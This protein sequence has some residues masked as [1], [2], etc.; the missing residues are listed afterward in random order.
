MTTT[1]WQSTLVAAIFAIHPLH[2]ESVAWIAERRDVLYAFFMLLT[3]WAYINYLEKPKRCRHLWVLL[4]FILAAMS[5]PMVV[6]MPFILLLLDYWPLGR[7]RMANQDRGSKPFTAPSLQAIRQNVPIFH[8]FVEKFSLFSIAAVISL[9][10][11]FS[12]WGANALSSLEALP[13]IVRLEN[14]VVSYRAYILKM[15]WPNPL[16]VLYPH[17]IALPV[18]KIVSAALLLLTI[19]ILVI[20]GRKKHP[21][22]I[23]GWLWYLITLLPVIGLVQA[24]IQSMADRFMYMPMTGLSIMVIYGISDIY[25]TWPYKKLTLTVLT[26]LLL[27][28]LIASTRAQVKLWQNSETLFRHTLQVTSNN[29]LI[30]NNLGATLA[31]QGKDEE[32]FIHFMR[33]LEINP[34]YA[35]AHYNLGSLLLRQGKDREAI[36]HLLVALQIK[37]DHV[38]AHNDLGI[39]LTRYGKSKEA[40]DHFSKAIQFDPTY[41]EAY[42]NEGYI[43]LQQKNYVEAIFYFKEVLRIN[44]NNS[45]AYNGLGVSFLESGSAEKAMD[46]Y[47]KALEINPNDADTH[48]NLGSLFIR[49]GKYQEAILHFT[50][51]LRI[52]P[53]DGEVHFTLGMLYLKIDQKEL[54]LKQYTILKTINN[55]MA[56]TLYR[57]ISRHRN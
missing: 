16:A 56:G 25:K 30:H 9:F 49:Q 8:L 53:N 42:F 51:A 46:C 1:L 47:H 28:T 15:I 24:G 32:A 41:E 43:L 52:N 31:K 55:K 20:V 22:L 48:V 12:S 33:S 17:P 37:P 36:P 13:L 23:V 18:S 14:A 6:T 38:Q 21:Y 5:K 3:I 44:P 4:C 29:Y 34:C 27:L 50:E 7:L 57:N 40:M 45:K 11:L 39:I 54:A 19:T 10:T 26:V 2:V 35:D